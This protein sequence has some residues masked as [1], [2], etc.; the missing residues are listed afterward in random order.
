MKL[1]LYSLF[2]LMSILFSEASAQKESLFYKMTDY[3]DNQNIDTNYVVKLLRRFSISPDMSIYLESCDFKYGDNEFEIESDPICKPGIKFGYKNLEI[4]YNFNISK[5]INEN[6]GDNHSMSISYYGQRFGAD[7]FSSR[8]E[9]YHFSSVNGKDTTAVIEGISSK[10]KQFRLYYVFNNKR[11]SNSSVFSHNTRQKINCGSFLAGLSVNYEKLRAQNSS[12]TP[13]Y[14]VVG[15]TSTISKISQTGICLDG[16]YAYNYVP[17]RKWLIHGSITGVFALY[18]KLKID[19]FDSSSDQYKKPGI[20]GLIRLGTQRDS[21]KWYYGF[22]FIFTINDVGFETV[23]VTKN[24]IRSD[25]FVG[26]RF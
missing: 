15:D 19:Y 2:V 23:E 10:Y 7:F 16:G 5:Y 9:N 12:I 14:N 8:T 25:F 26:I 20:G 24:H 6:E 4:G 17:G 1:R 3:R 18:R 13:I 21:G 22:N 11:F